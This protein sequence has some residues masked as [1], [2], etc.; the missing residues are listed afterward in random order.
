MRLTKKVFY[1]LAIWMSLFGLTI[2]II[3]PFFAVIIGVPQYIAITP[4][5]FTECIIAGI[6]VGVVN[7]TITKKVIGS[8]L[9]LLSYGMKHIK[10]TLNSVTKTGRLDICDE[11]KCSISIDS[12][13]EIGESAYSFNQLVES[14]THSMKTQNAIRTFSLLLASQLELDTL[15][16]KALSHFITHTGIAGGA[17]LYIDG[18][19]LNIASSIGIKN[20]DFILKSDIVTHTLKSLSPYKIRL[21]ESITLDGVLTDFR[22]LEVLIIPITDKGFP[23]GVVILASTQTFDQEA[24][25]RVDIFCQTLAL[26]MNN[27]LAH[28]KLKKLAAIDPLTGIYNRRFGMNRLREEFT[29]SVRSSSPLGILMIDIDFF[30]NINDTYG[31]LVG[32]RILKSITASA[33]SVLR[34]GDIMV[35]YGGEE[36]LII[37]PAASAVDLKTIGE[38]IRHAVEDTSI[39]EGDKIIK[40][41]ISV[42]GSAYPNDNVSHENELID[43]AD[44]TLYRAKQ[45][46][47]NR[48]EISI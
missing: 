15:A 42:G 7:Y 23:L 31:H 39:D 38:R 26:A 12:E 16:T 6:I 17:I 22:P 34:E 1:D 24:E 44:K 19:E 41:T 29:R 21:P 28:E 45:S 10:D 48:V 32:D 18:G 25:I 14:L 9:R 4:L 13:D 33:K 3:F 27:V 5:F 8:R 47:R 37:L 40:V 46:G 35:R 11:D 2:G 20:I 36:F 43:L 30:K